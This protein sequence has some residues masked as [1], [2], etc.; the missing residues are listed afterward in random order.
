MKRSLTAA[1][2]VA[3][4]FLMCAVI[5]VQRAIVKFGENDNNRSV[6]LRVDRKIEIDL[7]GNP[8]T[9]FEWVKTSGSRK[10]IR[11]NGVAEY[12]PDSKAIGSGGTT[13]FYFKIVGR[14]RTKL[15]LSYKRPWESGVPPVKTFTLRITAR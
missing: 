4:V 11:R 1:A 12:T 9:G 10:I 7:E 13:R 2:L 14:G 3:C 15:M 5:P 8:T 6:R